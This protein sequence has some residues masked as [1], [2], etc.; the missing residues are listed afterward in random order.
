MGDVFL[1][2]VFILKLKKIIGIRV[3]LRIPWEERLRF[4]LFLA[5]E[6]E[7]FGFVGG[8]MGDATGEDG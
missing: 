3:F 4:P 8:E 1:K 2:E 6:D 5:L 7:D